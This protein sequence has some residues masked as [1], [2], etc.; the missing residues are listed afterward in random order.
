MKNSAIAAL[1]ALTGTAGALLIGAATAQAAQSAQPI[2]CDGQQLMIRTNDNHSSEMGG[3]SAAQVVSGGS[4][5]LIPTTFT[6]GAYDD[7]TQQQLFVGEALKGAGNANHNQQT[8]T[9]TQV[10][11]DTLANLMEPGDQLPPGA[12]LDDQVTVTFAVTAV[13]QP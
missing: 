13:W 12:S 2:T 9:C 6:F 5:T 11:T 8:V 3:W 1:V 4:G 7:T 10:Q